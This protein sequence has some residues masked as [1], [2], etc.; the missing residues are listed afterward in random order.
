MAQS[1]RRPGLM[2]S[3]CT[4]QYTTA[5]C[6]ERLTGPR[7]HAEAERTGFSAP[8]RASN[9]STASSECSVGSAGVAARDERADNAPAR[10][11]G[12]HRNRALRPT[13]ESRCREFPSSRS[14]QLVGASERVGGGRSGSRVSVRGEGQ[15]FRGPTAQRVSVGSERSGWDQ[16]SSRPSRG[17]GFACAASVEPCVLADSGSRALAGLASPAELDEASARGRCVGTVQG[18]FRETLLS[19]A[20]S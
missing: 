17:G 15:R 4:I 3:C 16:S 18:A 2:P 20:A 12:P 1:A 8:H 5:S 13:R 7:A 6:S 9:E 11:L 14:P 10:E 19:L